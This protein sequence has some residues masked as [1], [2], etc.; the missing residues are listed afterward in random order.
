MAQVIFHFDVPRHFVSA[1]TFIAS[2]VATRQIADTIERYFFA[3]A[4][5]FE[6]FVGAPEAGSLLEI[7]KVRVKPIRDVAVLIAAI[8]SF[9]ATPMGQE[10]ARE[11]TGHTLQ[12][13]ALSSIQE[14]K[15]SPQSLKDWSAQ[16]I[17]NLTKTFEDLTASATE[18]TLKRPREE[19]HS[20]PL[21][22][23]LRF[24]LE[25]A[26][27]AF[28]SELL[29]DPQIAGIGF[30]REPSKFI[31]RK[32]FFKRAIP[33]QPLHDPDP[34]KEWDVSIVDIVVASPNFD[35]NDKKRL[36]KGRHHEHQLVFELA[37]EGFW[38][39][40]EKNRLEFSKFTQM[41]LQLATNFVNGKPARRIALRVLEFNGHEIASALDEQ[42]VR[43]LLGHFHAPSHDLP[44]FGEYE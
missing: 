19:I 5:E 32:D 17:E 26:Q 35:R 10:I 9:D 41:K 39:A 8:A 11:L 24:D 33:P 38:G 27:S 40:I 31:Q 18:R 34:P 15:E 3:S 1:D 22:E 42:H 43:A 7:L 2:T 16:E 23:Q 44:L 6:I 25:N 37:D 13:W 30:Q 20:A 29:K 12:E 28:Y 36:W 4:I 21:P 14:I